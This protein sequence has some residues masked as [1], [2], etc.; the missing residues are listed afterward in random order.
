MLN[1]GSF[2]KLPGGVGRLIRTDCLNLQVFLARCC[3]STG[4]VDV[5]RK[6]APSVRPDFER[7]RDFAPTIMRD[8]VFCLDPAWLVNACCQL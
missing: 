8:P 6:F 1:K 2:L 3:S 7:Y 4:L 5:S